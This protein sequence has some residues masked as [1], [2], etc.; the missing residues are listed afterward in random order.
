MRVLIDIPDEDIDWLDR[1]AGELGK[2]RAAL[3]REAI[4]D[5]RAEK[6]KR[7]IERFFGMWKAREDIADG[8]DH[9]RCVRE[10]WD[11]SWDGHPK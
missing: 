8:L 6:G 5:Y 9:Q 11:R 3:V 10:D 7:G 1:K 4:A 2:S